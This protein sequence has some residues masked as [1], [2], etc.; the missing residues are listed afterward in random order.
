MNLT[1]MYFNVNKIRKSIA[2]V[3]VYI[4]VHRMEEWEEE[5]N[6]GKR[7]VHAL[8]NHDRKI[9]WWKLK[10]VLII[11]ISNIWIFSTDSFFFLFWL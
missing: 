10:I 2:I 8:D 11:T 5:E 6:E 4:F 9:M 3:I 1:F 7:W